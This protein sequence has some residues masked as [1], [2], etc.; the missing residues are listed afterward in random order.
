M[1]REFTTK[2]RFYPLFPLGR[3]E[4]REGT[5]KKLEGQI[6]RAPNGRAHLLIRS[7]TFPGS[8]AS[9]IVLVAV[10]GALKNSFYSND[11]SRFR[12]TP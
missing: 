9:A 7:F 8:L 2:V 12:F 11:L 5:A 1:P 3:E 4:G 10:G 6:E